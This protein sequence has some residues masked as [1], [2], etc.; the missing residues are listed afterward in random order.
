[1]FDEKFCPT[2]ELKCHFDFWGSIHDQKTRSGAT[3]LALGLALAPAMVLIVPASAPPGAVVQA[4][5][6]L[7]FRAFFQKPKGQY[8]SGRAIH[9][10]AAPARFYAYL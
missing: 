2:H 1:M 10:R 7:P 3:A 8:A 4:K 9:L 6:L 5:T